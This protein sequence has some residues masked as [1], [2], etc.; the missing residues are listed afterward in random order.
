VIAKAVI[1]GAR[2][3]VESGRVWTPAQIAERRRAESEARWL[4]DFRRAA[5]YYLTTGTRFVPPPTPEERLLTAIFGTK[6]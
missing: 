3:A 6:K 1:D 2:A 4:R 5:Q